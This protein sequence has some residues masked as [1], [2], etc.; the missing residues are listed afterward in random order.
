VYLEIF[1][2]FFHYVSPNPKR[3]SAEH[4]GS[5]EPDLGNTGIVC[6]GELF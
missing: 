6:S 2:Y 4:Y 1:I 5:A 3:C